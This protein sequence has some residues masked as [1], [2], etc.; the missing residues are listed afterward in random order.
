MVALASI[1]DYA[2]VTG[3]YPADTARVA[4]L[5]E[6]AS[7]AVLARAHG[8]QIISA[9]VTSTVRPYEGA[10]Y[11]PQ[12]P[13]T[14]IESVVVDGVT[15]DSDRYRFEPGGNRRPALLYRR[16][17]GRDV[18]WDCGELTVTYTAGWDPVPG[19]IIGVVVAMS[20][21]VSDTGGSAPIIQESTGPFQVSVSAAAVQTPDM[22]L[23]E[24]AQS[25]IDALCSVTGPASVAIG[26]DQP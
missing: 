6:L 2:A 8:Q 17:A 15:L 5:I 22:A 14:A 23:T 10:A 25:I 11:L 4:R 12:R 13:V 26:R 24:S 20:K 9:T 1:D 18:W 19:Q 16:H 7:D 3:A 21:G